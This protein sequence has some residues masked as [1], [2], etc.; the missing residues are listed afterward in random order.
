MTLR[1]LYQGARPRWV[2]LR[3]W[4]HIFGV[5]YRAGRDDAVRR[6]QALADAR[7]REHAWYC[8]T[9]K[10]LLDGRHADPTDPVK[11]QELLGAWGENPPPIREH[12]TVPCPGTCTCPTG[13]DVAEI[14][15]A[16]AERT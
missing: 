5:G 1:W 16:L 2:R 7:D 4:E 8:C 15:T 14:R 9:V 3:T 6:V 10:C 11:I 12:R 13:P